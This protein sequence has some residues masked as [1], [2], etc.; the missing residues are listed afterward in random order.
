MMHIEKLWQKA[1]S[2]RGCLTKLKQ[3][4]SRR[5]YANDEDPLMM[6]DCFVSDEA[7]IL[8][9]KTFRALRSKTQVFTFPQNTMIRTRQAHVH[10]VVAC[11]VVCADML[12][13]NV[14]LLRAAAFGHDI[15]HVPFSHQGEAWMARAM[16]KPGFCHE[17]MG[18]VVAQSIERSGRGLNLNW[19]TLDAMMRHSGNTARDGMSQEAWVLRH[20]DK[21]AYIFHDVND[22]GLRMRYPISGE[23]LSLTNSFGEDQRQRTSTAIAG[24]VIESAECGKVCFEHSELGQKFTRLRTMMYEIYPRVTQQNVESIMGPVLECLNMLN[25]CDPFL[26][27]AFMTDEDAARLA[28]EPMKD[29]QAFNRTAVS[30]IVPY[31]SQI[32]PV[33]LCAPDLDW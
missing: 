7:K 33:D 12:G 10:E 2:L 24:L 30:E 8:S 15:G 26:L 28:K 20:T 32:G 4:S 25:L 11:S 18:V 19:H 27:L 22:I 17:V 6:H 31:L 3:D 9:S 16:G 1:N 5:R 23:L 21:F 13:L 14:N 29:M